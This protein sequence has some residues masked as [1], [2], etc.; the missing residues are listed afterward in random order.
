MFQIKFFIQKNQKTNKF[1]CTLSSLEEKHLL[2]DKS[3][4]FQNNQLVVTQLKNLQ[5][6]DRRHIYESWSI[7]SFLDHIEKILIAL[8][9]CSRHYMDHFQETIEYCLYLISWQRLKKPID[10][11]KYYL[12]D[13]HL[14]KV[15]IQLLYL[16]THFFFYCMLCN[17]SRIWQQELLLLITKRHYNKCILMSLEK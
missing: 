2:I 14:D 6:Y 5:C 13:H 8:N 3:F 10:Y 16:M 7:H 12:I 1:P 9:Y 17:W 15:Q 11:H 4:L